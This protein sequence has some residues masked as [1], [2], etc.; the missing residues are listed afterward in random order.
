MRHER[1]P[2]DVDLATYAVVVDV[3]PEGIRSRS[4]PDS[5]GIPLDVLLT[6]PSHHLSEVDGRVLVVCDVGV[7]SRIAAQRLIDLGYVAD[8]LAGGIEAWATAGLPIVDVPELDQRQRERYDRQIKLP[9]IGVAGQAAIGAAVVTVVGLGGLGV[10]VALYL[11]AAGIG[12]LRLVDPDMIEISNLQRQPIY[13]TRDVGSAKVEAASRVLEALDPAI[14][15]ETSPDTVTPATAT[16]LLAGSDVI[17]DATDR[18]EARYAISDA[19]Q[20]LGVPV[21]FG[22]VYRWEGQL[23]VFPPGGPCYRCAFPEPPDPGVELDCSVV[24]V[25]GS[26]V[27]TIGSMQATETLRWIASRGTVEA[28]R[29]VLYDARDHRTVSV[30]IETRAHCPG[31]GGRSS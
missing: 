20:R 8:S 1:Q 7:R 29:L 25:L 16:R 18:F 5:V 6:D 4:I 3:R 17:V 10:P 19:G 23:A 31:C 14:E 12:R 15:V 2:R 28:A 27:G 30:A 11:A 26:V 24:G 9:E 22:A 21:V 13:R